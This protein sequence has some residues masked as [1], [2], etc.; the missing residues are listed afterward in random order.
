M[1]F[2]IL[3]VTRK[4]TKN[5]IK[6]AFRKQSMLWHPDKF[7]ND[8]RK[9]EEAH[10]KFIQ[11]SQAYNLL[12]NYEPKKTFVAEKKK[13]SQDNYKPSSERKDITRVIVKSSNIFS[14]GYDPVNKILQVEFR[15]GSIYE[16]YDVPDN[17][18]QNFMSAES[19]GKFIPQLS[20]FKFQKCK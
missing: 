13:S 15:R 18:Y 12:R 8:E 14:I 10:L 11:I 4:S 3:G 20:K 9:W 2:E 17:I 6:T 7:S 19:K 5:E 16:Y 1:H